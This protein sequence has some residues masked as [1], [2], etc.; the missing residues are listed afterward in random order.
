MKIMYN[1]KEMDFL[2]VKELY[3]ACKALGKENAVIG[4]HHY[5]DNIDGDEHE[6]EVCEPIIQGDFNIGG[7]FETTPLKRITDAVWLEIIQ[8][9]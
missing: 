1:G 7:L 6:Y 3:E 8:R 4:V 2:T 5:N 9:D